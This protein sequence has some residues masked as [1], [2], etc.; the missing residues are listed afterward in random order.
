VAQLYPRALDSLF[1]A[2][3]DTQCYSGGILTRLHT[4]L[5]ILALSLDNLLMAL[6]YKASALIAQRTVFFIVV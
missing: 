4:G 6:H 2:S 5:T 3:Y 1:V